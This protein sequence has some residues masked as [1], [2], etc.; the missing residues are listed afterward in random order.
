MTPVASVRKVVEKN[1]CAR[2]EERIYV[3]DFE[4]FRRRNRSRLRL[5]RESTHYG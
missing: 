5:E 4:V 1:G 3:G 2:I